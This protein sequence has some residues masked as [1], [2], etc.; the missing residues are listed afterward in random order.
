MSGLFSGLT[1]GL[2]GLDKTGL[3]I[4]IGGGTE[5]EKTWARKVLPVREDGNRLLCTL[6][7]GNVIVN[8][9]LSIFAANLF[10]SLFGLFI[11]TGLIVIFGEILPQATCSRHALRVGASTVQLVKLFTMLLAP[12]AIPLAKGLDLLLEEDVGTVHTRKEMLQYMKVHVRR[13]ELDTE[14]GNV[15]KGALEMKEKPVSDVMTPL[16][17]IYMLPAQTRLNFNVVRDIFEHGFSRVPVFRG[18][19]ENIVGLLFVKDLIFVDPEDETPIASLL[20]IFK[21]RLQ[22]VDETNTLDDVLRIFKRGRGHLALVRAAAR[23]PRGTRRIRAAP[24]TRPPEPAQDNENLINDDNYEDRMLYRKPKVQRQKSHDSTSGQDKD[25]EDSCDVGGSIVS[26]IRRKTQQLMIRT[27][28][29]NDRVRIR[30]LKERNQM[31]P[32]LRRCAGQTHGSTANPQRGGTAL[33]DHDIVDVSLKEDSDLDAMTLN[34]S[35][36]DN[37]EHE[38]RDDAVSCPTLLIDNAVETASPEDN[39]A[40]KHTRVPPPS[41]CD[42][43]SHYHGYFD[44]GGEGED[45]DGDD[46]NPSEGLGD[47]IGIVTLEDIVE[48]IIGDEIIDET[49]VF[50]DVD[51]HVR[52]QGRSDFDFTRLRRLDAKYVDEHLSPEEVKAVTAYLLTNVVQLSSGDTKPRSAGSHNHGRVGKLGS[53]MKSS[54]SSFRED[55]QYTTAPPLSTTMTPRRLS[56]EEMASLVR[57]SKVVDMKRV[58]KAHADKPRKE[59]IVFARDVPASYAVLVLSGKL[60]VVAGKDRFRAQA[61]PWTVLGA[62]ALVT[63]ADEHYVPDFSANVATDVARLVYFHRADYA[64]AFSHHPGCG[65][66]VSSAPPA[67]SSSILEGVSTPHYRGTAGTAC[68]IGLEAT[69]SDDEQVF[70][71]QNRRELRRSGISS[72]RLTET[73]RRFELTKRRKKLTAATRAE[74]KR[75]FSRAAVDCTPNSKGSVPESRTLPETSFP[76]DESDFGAIPSATVC[77]LASTYAPASITM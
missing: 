28:I 38:V 10:D 13:G 21:R 58:S 61:G 67:M 52:V 32:P 34:R 46:D 9:G 4:V 16:E 68:T 56:K 48:E 69:S 60:S 23:S 27:N 1:L 57:R 64:R 45:A 24:I 39:V 19:R 26:K 66:T 17:D 29:S 44:D 30:E 42:R 15:M 55:S 63:P 40:T 71:E 76:T 31:Y 37:F 3:E 14:S 43:V 41:I 47:I 65:S 72:N 59:D 8:S 5:E 2:L 70:S 51:N 50:V 49:D 33:C 18:D 36:D 7:L 11:S 22:I 20:S 35:E 73:Q 74:S 53:N 77:S 75:T 25:I 6:L 12:V 62:D 54:S